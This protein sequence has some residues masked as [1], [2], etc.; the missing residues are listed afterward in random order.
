MKRLDA[1]VNKLNNQVLVKYFE[2]EWG[3]VTYQ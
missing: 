2:E 3:A 1:G